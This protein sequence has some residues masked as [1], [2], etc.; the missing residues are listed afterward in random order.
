MK[1]YYQSTRKLFVSL[2]FIVNCFAFYLDVKGQTGTVPCGFDYLLNQIKADSASN[3]DFDSVR[4]YISRQIE[5]NAGE[6][7]GLFRIQPNN[8]VIPV[9][10]HLV[11]T[12]A[13]TITAADVI[14]QIQ[15]LNDGFS[16]NLG[17]PIP[18]ADNAQIKF[19]LAQNTPVTGTTWSG[20]YNSLTPGITRWTSA[21]ENSV[22]V[23]HN[24]E[25][26]TLYGQ[27][28]FSV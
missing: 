12:A 5:Q 10:V 6:P 26:N 25:T 1:N 9:V 15:I 20:T 14:H 13:N 16:N 11:G 8:Y 22:A 7:G 24:M 18:V 4:V 23:A 2:L 27:L 3:A 17:S 28:E 19:C 21:W